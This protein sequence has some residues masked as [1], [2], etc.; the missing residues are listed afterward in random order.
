M[1][2][3]FNLFSTYGKMVIMEPQVFR[4]G[5]SHNMQIFQDSDYHQPFNVIEKYY[6]NI[7]THYYTHT[8]MAGNTKCHIIR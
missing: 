8:I 2:M 4:A 3:Y 1:Q 7:Q 5:F 6:I